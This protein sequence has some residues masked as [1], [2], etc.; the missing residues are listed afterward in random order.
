MTFDVILHDWIRRRD[1]FHFDFGRLST[2]CTFL[3]LFS[4]DLC[5]GSWRLGF[6]IFRWKNRQKQAKH[7]LSKDN[8]CRVPDVSRKHDLKTRRQALGA[9]RFTGSLFFSS[10]FF[11]IFF[12][13]QLR[14][15][16]FSAILCSHWNSRFLDTLVL[17][18][19]SAGAGTDFRW[20]RSVLRLPMG[21]PLHHSS[22]CITQ[23]HHQTFWQSQSLISHHQGTR[24]QRMSSCR[25]ESR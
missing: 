20:L 17:C 8:Q 24:R 13:Q 14:V 2:S 23:A 7:D 11:F 5:C 9:L 22:L 12:E 16:R 10:L 15:S 6:E 4:H 21:V 25:N 19:R 18:W 3:W 1:H